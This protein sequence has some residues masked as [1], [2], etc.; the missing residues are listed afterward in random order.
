MGASPEVNELLESLFD[1]IDYNQERIAIGRIK[2]SDN[3]DIHNRIVGEINKQL[4]KL[5]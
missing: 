3:E 5:L 1:K 4:M 2:I